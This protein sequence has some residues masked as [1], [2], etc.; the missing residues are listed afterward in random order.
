M[1][2]PLH[3]ARNLKF[4]LSIYSSKAFGHI[5]G[6]LTRRRG[7]AILLTR[8]LVITFFNELFPTLSEFTRIKKDL[9]LYLVH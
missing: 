3:K 2:L 9:F 1:F 4:S 7:A 6:L 8:H 5:M